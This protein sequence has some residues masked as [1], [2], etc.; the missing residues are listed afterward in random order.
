MRTLAVGAGTPAGLADCSTV[1]PDSPPPEQGSTLISTR[2]HCGAQSRSYMLEKLPDAQPH[3]CVEPPR[4]NVSFT[5][6][7]NPAVYM[8]PACGGPSNWNW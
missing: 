3:H 1:P 4:A 8:A 5:Q 2:L 6:M 7:E